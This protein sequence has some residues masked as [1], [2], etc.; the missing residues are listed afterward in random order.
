M[1]SSRIDRRDAERGSVVVS[2]ATVVCLMMLVCVVA[3]AA[4]LSLDHRIAQSAADLAALAAAADLVTAP[5]VA[6]ASG[7]DVANA[8]GTHVTQCLIA[9]DSVW[10][11]VA[12]ESVGGRMVTA[13]ARAGYGS[14]AD[15]A[16]Q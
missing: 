5:G 8:N 3:A 15:E 11:M 2:L 4:R 12:R 1:T 16:V 6:C 13:R 14:G 10:V 9:G 7:G